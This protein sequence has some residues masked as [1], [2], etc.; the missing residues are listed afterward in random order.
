MIFFFL[1][2][3][4][5]FVSVHMLHVASPMSEVNTDALPTC[6]QSASVPDHVPK[7]TESHHA[8]IEGDSE[9]RLQRVQQTLGQWEGGSKY[10][11]RSPPQENK[12]QTSRLGLAN[13]IQDG[14]N[15]QTPLRS[16]LSHLG[17]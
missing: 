5:R 4:E 16:R 13:K 14:C 2:L 17:I 10:G 6:A 7:L 11:A 9:Q 1:L 12:L 15:T 3:I 8:V